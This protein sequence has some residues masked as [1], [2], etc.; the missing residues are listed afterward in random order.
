MGQISKILNPEQ[1]VK[2]Q[3]LVEKQKEKIR[4]RLIERQNKNVDLAK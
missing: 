1:Y 4:N 2:Y 3:A